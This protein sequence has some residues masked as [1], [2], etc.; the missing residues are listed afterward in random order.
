MLADEF[1]FGQMSS[2]EDAALENL[3]RAAENRR[4]GSTLQYGAKHSLY[5]TTGLHADSVVA[6][7]VP[8]GHSVQQCSSAPASA[9][10]NASKT[11]NQQQQPTC[12]VPCDQS[13]GLDSEDPG[14]KSTCLECKLMPRPAKPGAVP[15]M[16]GK[17]KLPN[18]F[19][20]GQQNGQP[21]A[22]SALRPLCLPK[23][24]IA[25]ASLPEEVEHLCK[26]VLSSGVEAVGFDIE[27]RVT[28]RTGET[29]RSVALIQLAVQLQDGKY[30]VFLLHVCHSGLTPTLLTILRSPAVKK[31]GVGCCG[32]AQKLMRDFGVECEG[33]VD[34]S[35]EANLRLYGP[36]CGRLPEKWSLARLAAAMLSAEVEKDQGLRTSNWETWPLSLEQQH[37]AAL[38]AFASLLLYQRIMALPIVQL[39]AEPPQPDEEASDEDQILLDVP[40]EPTMVPLQPAKMAVWRIF[41]EQGASLCTIARQRNIQ[42]D[43]AE[44]YLAEAMTAGAAYAWH[45]TRVPRAVLAAVAAAAARHLCPPAQPGI[46]AQR[47]GCSND[48]QAGAVSDSSEHAPPVAGPIKEE[49]C[50]PAQPACRAGQP[51]NPAQRSGHSNNQQAGAVSK[52]S[53]HASPVAGPIK[54]DMCTPAK[55]ACLAQEVTFPVHRLARAD[56]KQA[57]AASSRHAGIKTGVQQPGLPSQDALHSSVSPGDCRVAAAE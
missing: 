18:S 16:L 53:V 30:R 57:G 34:L 50:P 12:S 35:E 47:P 15:A 38:D 4:A 27:W 56:D 51:S 37:Y 7:V 22:A 46:P 52:P 9:P 1:D 55:P 32:D 39:P 19:N 17:R 41:M 6:P 36:G 14:Q 44:A 26:V 2:Q 13:M 40:A 49:K 48:Q 25:Y 43:S 24:C 29:P 42:R 28:Y 3:L 31:A 45:R 5:C 23:G 11:Q 20:S 33:L 10:L 21:G 8:F 54:E